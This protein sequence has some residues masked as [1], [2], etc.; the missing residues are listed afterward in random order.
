MWWEYLIL[1]A[2][3]LLN[4]FFAMS[5]MAL[6]SSHP[7]EL[8]RR[9]ELGQR[10]AAAVLHLTQDLSRLLSAVQIG[11]TLVGIVAGAYSGTT[12]GAEL[13][14]YLGR[15]FP[16]L[17]PWTDEAAMTIVVGAIT[18]LSLVVG[19]L[20]P[21]R[22]ALRH[23]ETIASRVAP[24]MRLVT[25]IGGPMVDLLGWSTDRVLV[26]LGQKPGHDN[27]VT[28]EE[29]RAVIA[30]GALSGAI[31]PMEKEMIERVMRLAD[32]TVGSIMTPRPEIE[33]LDLDAPAETWGRQLGLSSHTRYPV[34]RGSLRDVEGVAD[35]RLLLTRLAAD[36]GTDPKTCV[37]QPPW[38]Q[39]D[40]RALGL[41]EL[42][43][44]NRMPFA[45]VRDANGRFEGVVTRS[46]ILAA[47]AGELDPKPPEESV[48]ICRPDGSWMVDGLLPIH[49][50]EALTGIP[51]LAGNNSFHT[52]AGFMLAHLSR[53]PQVG[54][55]LTWAGW[56]FEVLR[57]EGLRI[58]RIL[59]EPSQPQRDTPP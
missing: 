14:T 26:L 47:I 45:L 28:E 20:V 11:I 16:A 27:S 22:L 29:V 9:A 3:I 55:S 51:G 32:R 8:R 33:W 1:A 25:R 52:L 58:D 13:A 39:D 10:G 37:V 40:S 15:E 41:I 57:M 6:V 12:L 23:A 17:A 36:P 34:A 4:G 31:E 38:V 42:F 19:E 24:I 35:T 43:R 5:E 49:E 44:A 7:A 21:K 2:L 50:A 54:D 18:Y 46:D 48:A 30:E 53:F 56:R 59:I